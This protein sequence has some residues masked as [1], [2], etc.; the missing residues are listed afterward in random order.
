MIWLQNKNYLKHR[1]NSNFISDL[2][3]DE[4]RDLLISGSEDKSIAFTRLDE[5][6]IHKKYVNLSHDV[7]GIRFIW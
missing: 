5:R 3:Y 4:R 7:L 6:R 1:P 2:D